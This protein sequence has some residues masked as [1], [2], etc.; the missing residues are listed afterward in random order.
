M[1]QSLHMTAYTCKHWPFYV[2]EGSES[3]LLRL[4]M[5]WLHCMAWA[6]LACTTDVRTGIV[7]TCTSSKSMC[8]GI[9][10]R[11]GMP[12]STAPRGHL[13]WWSIS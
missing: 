5:F 9:T 3:C 8:A 13:A 4:C 1:M 6:L 10:T 7:V 12:F 11:T 2:D